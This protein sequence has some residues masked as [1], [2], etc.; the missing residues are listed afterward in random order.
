VLNAACA[1]AARWH[2]GGFDVG[3]AVNVSPRQ[4]AHSEFVGTLAQAL[5]D[6]GV[7][8][9]KLEIEIT[10][11]AIMSNAEPV[12]TTLQAVHAMGIR[13][14][15]DD[16]GTGYSSFA[17]LKRFEVDSLKIDRTFVEGIERDDNVAIARSIV[18]VA[19]A[20]GLPVTAEGVETAQQA[21]ILTALGCD[22]LQGF[23]FGRPS[24]GTEFEAARVELVPT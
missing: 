13:V 7:A 21:R 12:L 1:Q 18:S 5:R 15:I 11:A 6:S 17:Y 23:Y 2:R 4:L 10:E 16:F 24:P 9:E 8:P 22:R 14:A 20:L 19:H 3:V